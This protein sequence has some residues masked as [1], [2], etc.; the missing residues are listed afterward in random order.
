MSFM[1]CQDVRYEG[2]TYST[3]KM[4]AELSPVE[5][6][7]VEP[8][9]GDAEGSL[10]AAMASFHQ[11]LEALEAGCNRYGPFSV[12]MC[13]RAT[14]DGP[15]AFA[16]VE[17]PSLAWAWDAIVEVFADIGDAWARSTESNVYVY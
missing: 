8:L 3:A 1:V 9:C 10:A 11:K 12:F 14:P 2:T 6:A 4:K 13:D 17:K 5:E 15:T 7:F 16:A